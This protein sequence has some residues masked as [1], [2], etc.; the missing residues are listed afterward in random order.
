MLS[1]PSRSWYLDPFNIELLSSLVYGILGDFST[2]IHKKVMLQRGVKLV[3]T[4]VGIC[5]EARLV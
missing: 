2:F 3:P 1:F 4:S 5:G